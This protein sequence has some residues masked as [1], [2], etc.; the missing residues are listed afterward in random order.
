MVTRQPRDF[1][2]C[3]VDGD[4]EMESLQVYEP[5]QKAYRYLSMQQ[6]RTT[7]KAFSYQYTADGLLSWAYLPTD[8]YPGAAAIY[9]AMET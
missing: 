9:D 3:L 6:F 2:H 7:D 5:C 8:S 4:V 1:S